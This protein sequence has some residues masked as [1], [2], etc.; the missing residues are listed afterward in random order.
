MATKLEKSLKREIQASG[1]PYVVTQ[2][3]LAAALNASLGR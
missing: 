3:A 1:Q 2:Q